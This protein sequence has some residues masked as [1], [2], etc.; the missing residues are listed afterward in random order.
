MITSTYCITRYII[1]YFLTV[2][3]FV[4]FSTSDPAGSGF[5]LNDGKIEKFSFRFSWFFKGTF[6]G[7]HNID[8]QA[9]IL[10]LLLSFWADDV[11]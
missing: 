4:K 2:L 8:L 9:I 6:S 11:T 10:L 3:A 7:L 5:L 1:S